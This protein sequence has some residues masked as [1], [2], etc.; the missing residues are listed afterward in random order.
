MLAEALEAIVEDV[1]ED[2]RVKV[3]EVL[4]EVV[5]STG[6]GSNL[7]SSHLQRWAKNLR[8]KLFVRLIP[9]CLALYALY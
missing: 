6:Q 4:P 7:I 3:L 2:V 9:P 1:E 8:W 5:A